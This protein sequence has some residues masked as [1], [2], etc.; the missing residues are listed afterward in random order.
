MKKEN[1]TSTELNWYKIL[2]RVEY[3]TGMPRRQVKIANEEW[4][5]HCA[6]QLSK[7]VC[8]VMF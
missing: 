6:L 2:K 8:P 4:W 3:P 7:N 5:R 1:C